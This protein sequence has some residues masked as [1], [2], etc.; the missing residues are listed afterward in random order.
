MI[1]FITISSVSLSFL[2]NKEKERSLK[3]L[4]KVTRTLGV[5]Q[6]LHGSN[7]T[8]VETKA[9]QLTQPQGPELLGSLGWVR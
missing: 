5:H 3:P 7:L 8:A 1:D 6:H 4:L 2:P 9:G